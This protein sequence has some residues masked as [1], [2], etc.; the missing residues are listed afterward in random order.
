MVKFDPGTLVTPE[1]LEQVTDEL[2]SQPQKYRV[3]NLVLD[4]RNVKPDP[5]V[6]YEEL[7]QIAVHI[8][9]GWENGWTHEKTA[10]VVTDKVTFGM[11][12]IYAAL[13]DVQ[14]NY[15]VRIFDND[16]EAAIQWAQPKG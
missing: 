3:T 9:A 1:M 15:R 12:R 16:L 5:I 13:A 4:L 14:L 6:G 7:S 11:S 8:Q 10:V 2:N